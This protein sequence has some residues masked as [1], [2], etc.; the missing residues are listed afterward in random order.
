MAPY[1]QGGLDPDLRFKVTVT[2]GAAPTATPTTLDFPDYGGY[3][4][5]KPPGYVYEDLR[6]TCAACLWTVVA[7][8]TLAVLAR[9]Y[10]R[11][12]ITRIVGLEDWLMP[13][14]LVSSSAHWGEN[15]GTDGGLDCRWR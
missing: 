11:Y 3:A 7:L 6:P 10:T 13:V 15:P 14:A 12:R 2:S 9:L 5:P 1:E 8:G 4:A